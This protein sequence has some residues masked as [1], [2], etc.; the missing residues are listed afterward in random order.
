MMRRALNKV[1]SHV[2]LGRNF[3]RL[4]AADVENNSNAVV[5]KMPPFDYTPPPYDGPRGDE[6]LK[7]R[8]KFLSPS[9]FHFYKK[10]VSLF[11]TYFQKNGGV[12]KF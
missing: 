10:P 3:C 7:K 4:A 9:L 12:S 2:G 11:R 1:S 8:S 5:P 6:I